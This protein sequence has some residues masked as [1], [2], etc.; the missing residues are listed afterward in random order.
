VEPLQNT[1][2]QQQ[3]GRGSADEHKIVRFATH[4]QL[5]ASLLKMMGTWV[6]LSILAASCRSEAAVFTEHARSCSMFLW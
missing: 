5:S 1:C 4:K 3:Q 6:W 2:K